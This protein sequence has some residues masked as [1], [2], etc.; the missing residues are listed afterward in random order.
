MQDKRTFHRG[1]PLDPKFGL[2]PKH[3]YGA[4][5][6]AFTLSAAAL[7]GK[8]I[9]LSGVDFIPGSDDA[10]AELRF[11]LDGVSFAA[12]EDPSDGYRSMLEGVFVCKEPIKNTFPAVNV[13]ISKVESETD[14]LYRMTTALGDVVVEFGTENTE[15]YYPCFVSHFN[16]HMLGKV[17]NER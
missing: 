1:L 2:C 6:P 7:I 15:D 12:I 17:P 8:N 13:N 11:I 14:D 16:P 9:L 10:P 4:C 3:N 5:N